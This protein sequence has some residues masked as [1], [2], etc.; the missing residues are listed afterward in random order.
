MGEKG[1]SKDALRTLKNNH[2]KA[3]EAMGFEMAGEGGHRF[4]PTTGQNATQDPETGTWTDNKTG[5]PI[6]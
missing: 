1:L 2:S 6:M 4:N 5:E 3:M